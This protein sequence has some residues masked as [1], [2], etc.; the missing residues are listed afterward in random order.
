[1]FVCES[2]HEKDLSVTKC[3]DTYDTHIVEVWGDCDI[4]GN[5]D[6]GTV[7]CLDYDDC[8]EIPYEG[9]MTDE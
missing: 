2:C 9:E 3:A 4:C 5:N 7:W 8:E 1:M 6:I